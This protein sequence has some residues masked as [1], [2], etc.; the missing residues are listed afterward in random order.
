MIKI[1]L[2]YGLFPYP[3]R[4]KPGNEPGNEPGNQAA[5]IPATD[6]YFQAIHSFGNSN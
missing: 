2:I 1:S 3:D 5:T 4:E 6:R